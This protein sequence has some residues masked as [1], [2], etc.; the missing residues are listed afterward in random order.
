[1]PI[2][3]KGRHR[4]VILDRGLPYIRFLCIFVILAIDVWQ[5]GDRSMQRSAV[6]Y[7]SPVSD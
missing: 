4:L 6:L 1:M 3:K 5:T 2:M 7:E